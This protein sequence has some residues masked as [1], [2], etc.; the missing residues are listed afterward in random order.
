MI[1]IGFL[2]TVQQSRKAIR[3]QDRLISL[4]CELHIWTNVIIKHKY[5]YSVSI[6]S[7][8]LTKIKEHDNYAEPSIY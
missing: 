4:E 7:T 5:Y 3:V 8:K 2:V 6:F 1:Y